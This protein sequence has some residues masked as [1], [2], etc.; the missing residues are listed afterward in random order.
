MVCFYIRS[1]NQ[2]YRFEQ[3]ASWLHTDYRRLYEWYS[4]YGTC[5]STTLGADFASYNIRDSFDLTAD[6][7]A[8]PHFKAIPNH[9]VNFMSRWSANYER[10]ILLNAALDLEVCALSVDYADFDYK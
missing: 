4:V 3:Y 5:K 6:V 10:D 2:Y 1:K 9:C 8:D 7:H